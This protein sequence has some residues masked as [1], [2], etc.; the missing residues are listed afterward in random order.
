MR[1]ADASLV[2][3]VVG[4][5]AAVLQLGPVVGHGYV[6][7]RDLEF[8][9]HLPLTAQLLGVD[10]VPRA[11]PS[12]LVVA[13]LSRVIPADAV[14]DIVLVTVVALGAW[15]AGRLLRPSVPGAAAAAL[16]YGWNPY[17]TEH[18]LLGQWAVLMG[19]AALPWVAAA[20]LAVRRGES[21]SARRLFLWSAFAAVGG[22]SAELLAVLVAL[23]LVAWPGGVHPARSVSTAVGGFVVLALPWALPALSRPGAAPP[24]RVGVQLFAARPDT[25]LGTV[26][27]LLTLGGVW[28]GDAVPPGRDVLLVSL[29]ALAV[30]LV[31]LWGVVRLQRQWEPAAVRALGV[32]GA[33]GLLLALWGAIPG[34]RSGLAWLTARSEAL[35]LL[36]DGQRSLAPFVLLVAVGW[37]WAVH[38]LVARRRRALALLA[39]PALLLPAAA[40]GADGALGAVGWPRDWTI[41]TAASRQLPPGPVLVL[42][43]GAERSYSWNSLRP[44]ID[45]TARWLPARVVGDTRNFVD[46]RNTPQ[47]DPLAEQVQPAVS[48]GGPLVPKLEAL[49]Y[50]GV[51]VQLN[52]PGAAAAIGRLAGA[53]VVRKTPTLALYGVPA[54]RPA[55]IPHGPVALALFGDALPLLVIAL[56]SVSL[57]VTR[58]RAGRAG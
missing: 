27:S 5:L 4:L 16:L 12:D 2:A 11:V 28:N 22:A 46:G 48:G 49:G 25:P 13:L 53:T 1:R 42:P 14:E 47:E 8:V 35:D 33:L 38:E 9:P 26:G 44:L 37:G 31:A 3:G 36:R 54:G 15:G 10:T 23:P 43:W 58:R 30:T 20:A 45:P 50:R 41:V 24:D 21:G 32:A 55:R 19:Y 51:L 57:I 17:L 52:Q 7:L 6:L 29:I 34:A 18:L 56:S 39:V 40:W